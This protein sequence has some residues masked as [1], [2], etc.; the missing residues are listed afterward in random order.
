MTEEPAR[1][2]ILRLW[3][4]L[5]VTMQ[6]EITDHLAEQVS[7]ELL[8]M[9]HVEGADGLVLDLTGVWSMDSHLCAALSRLAQS[10]GLMGTP[11]IITGLSPEIAQTLQMM[12]IELD[13][14][15]ALT[16]ELALERL[17]ISVRLVSPRSGAGLTLKNPFERPSPWGDTH[18][19]DDEQS[20]AGKAN[21]GRTGTG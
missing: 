8:Q 12:G 15:T 10:A 2:P 7:E 6:G 19:N 11:T 20:A 9:I 4:R 13:V 3:G 1:V 5:L 16:V 17:G 18:L 14:Q 21:D